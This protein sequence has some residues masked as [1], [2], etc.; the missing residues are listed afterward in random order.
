M[1]KEPTPPRSPCYKSPAQLN[2]PPFTPSTAHSSQ[3]DQPLTTSNQN[4]NTMADTHLE[5]QGDKV[6]VSGAP[7]V[8]E[9]QGRTVA[10]LKSTSDRQEKAGDKVRFSFAE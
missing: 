9:P 2:S 1:R 5:V 4:T 7:R 6:F 3:F 8:H 10:D